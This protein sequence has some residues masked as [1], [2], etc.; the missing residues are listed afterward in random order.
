MNPTQPDRSRLSS[1]GSQGDPYENVETRPGI[2]EKQKEEGRSAYTDLLEAHARWAG[3]TLLG[4]DFPKDFKS[5]GGTTLL[6]QSIKSGFDLAVMAQI[7]QDRGY[8]TFSL[9]YSQQQRIISIC[10]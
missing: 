8:E 7:L 9:I 3:G 10:G 1:E 5:Q 6:N 2:T 4:S